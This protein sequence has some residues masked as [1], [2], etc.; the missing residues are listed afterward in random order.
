MLFIYLFI[1]GG[2]GRGRGIGYENKFLNPKTD[3]RFLFIYLCFWRNPKR[4]ISPK[5]PHSK[6]ILRIK[7]KS[8]SFRFVIQM[9]SWERI[10]KKCIW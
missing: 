1:L 7:S 8:I 2:R 9:F 5:Y 3:L 6:R 10:R 4:I